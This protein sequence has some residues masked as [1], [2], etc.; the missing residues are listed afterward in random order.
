MFETSVNC[1]EER[2][3]QEVQ[4]VLQPASIPSFEEPLKGTRPDVP[5]LF[6]HDDTVLTLLGRFLTI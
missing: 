1:G 2:Q 5:S 6:V 4:S 3:L